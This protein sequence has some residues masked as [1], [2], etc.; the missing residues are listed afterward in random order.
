MA[1]TAQVFAEGVL[2]GS[3]AEYYAC[4]AGTTAIIHA[5]TLTNGSGGVVACSVWLN[6][7]SGGT[8]RLLIDTHAL[9]DAESYACPELINQVLEAGG[10]IDALGDG[11]TLYVS[12]AEVV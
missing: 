7:R 6:P 8:D 1:V 12:G 11:V 9:A 4:P 5:A 10:T 2:T 3:Q